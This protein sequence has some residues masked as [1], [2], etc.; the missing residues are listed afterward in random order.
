MTQA[1]NW[2]RQGKLDQARE[3]LE[4]VRQRGLGSPQENES[5]G[6]YEAADM[7]SYSLR[8]GEVEESQRLSAALPVDPTQNVMFTIKRHVLT[9][10]LREIEGEPRSAVGALEEAV[11]LAHQGYRFQFTFAGSMILPVL[12]R[13]VGRTKHD[14]FVRSVIKLFPEEDGRRPEQPIDP[15]TDRELDVL[16]EIA[17]GYTNVEIAD[18]L[19]I[20]RGTVKRH[21]SNI[22]MKLA[23]HHRAEAVAKGRELGLID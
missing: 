10:A 5:L 7:L 6:F 11:E 17:A 4:L 20:S 12:N 15:L 22:Y 23:T 18:R 2:W 13:M 1:R 19:F 9:A 16:V 21:A 3:V 14:E 8:R